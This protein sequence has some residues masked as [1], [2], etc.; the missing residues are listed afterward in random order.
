MSAWVG[1]LEAN[2]ACASTHPSL[3]PVSLAGGYSWGLGPVPPLSPT[4][5]SALD[6]PVGPEEDEARQTVALI[7]GV[8]GS[9][10]TP[11]FLRGVLSFL[12][13]WIAT[14]QLLSS[15]FGLYFHQHLAGS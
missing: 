14:C 4:P 7:A 9:L 1:I 2:S 6:G 15:L 11:L 13:W 3:H 8:L 12:I 10:L 5:S